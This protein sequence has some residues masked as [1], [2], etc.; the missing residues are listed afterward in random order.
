MVVPFGIQHASDLYDSDVEEVYVNLQTREPFPRRDLCAPST[1]LDL[2]TRTS[3]S[4]AQVQ[5]EPFDLRCAPADDS[6]FY[7]GQRYAMEEV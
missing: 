7:H 3:I 4:R 5:A 2:G 6:L 1:P